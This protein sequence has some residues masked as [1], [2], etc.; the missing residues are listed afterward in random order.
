MEPVPRRAERR[1]ARSHGRRL[2][3]LTGKTSLYCPMNASSAP[4][5]S[6][7][8][9]TALYQL[10]SSLRYVSPWLRHLGLGCG[11]TATPTCP[12]HGLRTYHPRGTAHAT[13]LGRLSNLRCQQ[14]C[15][16]RK[17]RAQQ[18]DRVH[19]VEEDGQR[20]HHQRRE[21][22]HVRAQRARRG[23]VMVRGGTATAQLA[24]DK[25]G[26]RHGHRDQGDLMDAAARMPGHE[27]APTRGAGSDGDRA[28]GM[29]HRGGGDA[30]TPL[31]VR[32]GRRR[33]PHAWA[34]VWARQQG[35][36]AC[37]WLGFEPL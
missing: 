33:C 9:L 12:S 24:G 13:A 23:M 32:E 10:G 17:Q 34:L 16:R 35:R 7:P 30:R 11:H 4:W 20:R 6:P 5:S 26:Q 28:E 36:F 29:V 31:C 2:P 15:R 14:Q 18:D 21:L 19:G 1:A 8:S 22:H 27:A 25:H 3:K 37:H